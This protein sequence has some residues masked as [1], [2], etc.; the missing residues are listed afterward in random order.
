MYGGFGSRK[1]VIAGVE[2]VLTL[3]SEEL[4]FFYG[5]DIDLISDGAGASPGRVYCDS[6]THHHQ[7]LH[8]TA[9]KN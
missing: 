5:I 8:R 9:G 2:G 4:E 7:Y 1:A 3:L 6:G